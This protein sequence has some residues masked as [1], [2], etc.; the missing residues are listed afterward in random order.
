MCSATPVHRSTAPLA[1]APSLH[2]CPAD[3][4]R[5]VPLDD[6]I[7]GVNLTAA[8]Q[9]KPFTVVILKAASLPAYLPEC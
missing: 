8:L 4:G 2:L 7:A 3:E 9:D 6:G 5:I 1:A